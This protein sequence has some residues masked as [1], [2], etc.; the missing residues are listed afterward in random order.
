MTLHG[1]PERRLLAPEVVQTSA[2]DCGPASLKCLL[3]GFG[4]PVA[5]G[6]LREACQTDVDGTSI[7]TMEELAR[8][9]G[10]DAEQL[11]LP[12]E[13]LLLDEARALPAIVV[14]RMPNG[15]THF[16]VIW[17]RLGDRVQVMDPAIGRRWLP[18]AALLRDLFIH[19]M[20]VPAGA[21]R[22]WLGADDFQRPL[23]RRL[24]ALGVPAA[25]RLSQ[26]L[27]DP[28]WRSIAALDAAARMVE[29][30]VRAGGALSGRP[31]ARLLDALV[32]QAARDDAAIP[33][34]FWSVRPLPAAEDGYEQATLRGA[35]VVRM[36]GRLAGAA[37]AELSPELR[38]ALAEPPARPW[39]DLLGLL[40]GQGLFAPAALVSGLALSAAGRVIEAVLLRG[41]LQVGRELRL[42]EQ[43]AVGAAA[44]LLVLIALAGLELPVLWGL[45]RLGRHLEAG[46]RTAFFAKIPRLGDRYFQSRPMSDMAERGH[47]AHLLRAVPPMGG[48]LL[49]SVLGLAAT[50][51]AIGWV[52]RPSALP[53]AAASALLL[54]VPLLANGALIERDLRLRTHGGALTRFYLDA[55][56]G[57]VP[58][59]AH[60]AERA[61]RR[62]H[63]GLLV[64]WARAGRALLRAATLA[65]GT[66][67]LLGFGFAAW[68]LLD[69]VARGGPAARAL[70]LLYWALALPAIGRDVAETLRRYP[71][72]RNVA[73]R[74]LE[75]LGAPDD[76]PAEGSPAGSGGAMGGLGG[77]QI[78][79]R[80]EERQAS[81]VAASALDEATRA[82]GGPR[83]PSPQGIA[84]R[85]EDVVVRAG[86]HTLLD[87]VSLDIPAG[88][89]V[90]I[91]G[92]SGAG[93]SSLVG[94][95][96]GWHRPAAG[97]V[98]AGGAPLDAA[99][100]DRLRC[101]TAW[102]DPAVQLHNRTF[103]ANLQ[104]GA[105]GGA[106]SMGSILERAQ[107]REV[108]EKL[109]E[110]QQTVLG[111]GGALLSGGEGQR[112]R[113]GRALGRRD[114]RLVILD[115]PFRGLDRARR[116]E[117][118]ARARAVW[119]R[120]TLLCVTHDVGDT[121]GFE[122]VIVV[123]RGRVVEDGAPAD[124]AAR[125]G[126]RYAALIEAEAAM[127]DGL[128][129][130]A[131]WRRL[132]IE[133][134]AVVSGEE[135]RA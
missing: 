127:I 97:R 63:E 60:G 29:S 13:H 68:L 125:P 129:A 101:E 107:L 21:L 82:E 38:A 56:L 37:S 46:L 100:L 6:R 93:K 98:L 26:A 32:E 41:L 120:A 4:I 130:S 117:M 33:D 36:K 31:A 104:Y 58:I 109:P 50:T 70:L 57:L 48:E 74:L 3:E 54:G 119:S 92:S 69:F 95:L 30:V 128:W 34:R 52:D 9:L 123:E 62:E 23:G 59:R 99:H 49:R 45:L 122:R 71:E 78:E 133:Q 14:I 24:A 55:L 8:S 91:V 121:R 103:L 132:R 113:F 131:A 1:G 76:G 96:L 43:R 42:A 10:L 94:L 112:V 11:L 79:A 124:L 66:S 87:G 88:G 16:V 77:Q 22:G 89:H 126:S 116:R 114:A 72:V 111:E 81:A 90:A 53:A 2:M 39:R 102:L 64:E 84:V 67:A 28:T 85:L 40:R 86:G 12:P 105:P 51:A 35:V 83:A 15:A 27:A 115:E 5:Y 80:A 47:S 118:L 135:A 61:V 20:A 110:G 108:L 18:R 7:D 44:L 17:G 73:L 25:G 134:G 65:E 106:P 19:G 75:P